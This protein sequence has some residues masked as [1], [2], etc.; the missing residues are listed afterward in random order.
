MDDM[1]SCAHDLRDAVKHFMRNMGMLEGKKAFC[2]DFTYSQCHTLFE[3]GN[4]EAISLIELSQR[5]HMDKSA[6]S[7]IV[8]DLVKR[9]Y[10]KRE[11]D[12]Q[13]RR[14]VVIELTEIGKTVHQQIAENS[15]RQFSQVVAALPENE[16]HSIIN[17]L[18][19]LN[20]AIAAS[21]GS[22]ENNSLDE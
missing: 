8:D 5:L 3:I 22:T 9:G 2:C 7:R 19:A 16:R 21:L 10:L 15:L 1:R 13:D 20:K 4:S 11:Q 12:K 14:Y 6:M 17:G 18:T